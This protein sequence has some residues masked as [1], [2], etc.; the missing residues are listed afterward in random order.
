[1][2][3]IY[4]LKKFHSFSSLLFAFSISERVLEIYVW[5]FISIKLRK[6]KK[7]I[8]FLGFYFSD[9]KLQRRRKIVSNNIFILDQKQNQNFYSIERE[10]SFDCGVNSCVNVIFSNFFGLHSFRQN[11]LVAYFVHDYRNDNPLH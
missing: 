9:N 2:F 8:F 10:T 5:I 1:M 3:F 4:F 7:L 11:F 6:T